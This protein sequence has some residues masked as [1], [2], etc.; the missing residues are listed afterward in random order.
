MKKSATKGAM[1]LVAHRGDAKSLLAFDLTTAASRQ[2]LAGFT[3]RIT[4]PGKPPYF[5]LNS[6]RF[7]RP[8]DHSQVMSEPARS[9]VNA[10][11]HK[12]RWVHVPGSFHQGLDPAWGEYLYEVT[13]RYFDG[14][15]R[16]LP[17]DPD[18]TAKVKIEVAPFRKGKLTVGFTRG[19]TQSQA[20]TNN[21]GKNA[22]IKPDNA[23]ILFDTSQ[24]CGT[25]AEGVKHSYEELYAW[26]GFTAR[27]LINGCLDEVINGGPTYSVDIFAY[28]L[29]E[30][31]VVDRLLKLAAAGKARVLLDNAG[32]HHASDNSKPE[33]KVEQMF[34]AAATGAAVIKRGKFGRYAHDKVFIVKKSGQPIK[35]LT[36]STNFS[37]TGHYVNSNH[38]LLYDD[39]HVAKCF[40]DVFNFAWQTDAKAPPFRASGLSQNPFVFQGGQL[41]KTTI[42]FSPHREA[43]ARQALKLI[44]DR[45]DGERNN[46]GGLGNVLF[47]VM[48][49]GSNAENPVYDSLN[50]V[51]KDDTVFSFGISDNPDGIELYRIGKKNGVLVTG[52][53]AK[54]RLPPPFNQVRTIGLGHQIHHKFVVCDINGANPT[55]FCGSSNLALGGEQDNGDNLLMIEDED[56]VMVFA[57]EALGLID[58]FNFLNRVATAPQGQPSA[59]PPAVPTDA[60]AAAEWFL[61][62]TDFWA[63]KFFDPGDLHSKDRQIFAR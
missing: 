4:P 31:G 37:V 23:P 17:L 51:H 30:P 39:K 60:A 8:G 9:T 3:V 46:T 63:K 20:F 53:P 16:L 33:D 26:S 6:L 25:N 52:K 21:F 2:K 38:V 19:F 1:R 57:I 36:G 11:I 50:A 40:A 10:P 32:L 27:A 28:D 13:P 43:D 54:T 47:A 12:F 44:T 15:K 58:H 49:L 14:Q 34:A 55:V 24:V 5:M 18:L 62:T 56:I 59:P 61:G 41:P 42:R 7:E 45:V 29:N 22:K 48:E 35:V